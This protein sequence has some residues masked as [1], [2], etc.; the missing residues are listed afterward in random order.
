MTLP[1]SRCST[2]TEP[3]RHHTGPYQDLL[4][5]E[6]S[7]TGAYLSGRMVDEDVPDE[8]F[9]SALADLPKVPL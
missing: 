9:A 3:M 6:R 4:R 8:R 1:C 2:V 5:N 7:I